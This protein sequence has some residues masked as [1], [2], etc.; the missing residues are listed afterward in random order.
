MTNVCIVY[1]NQSHGL[2]WVSSDSYHMKP[3][4]DGA[5]VMVSGVSVPCH[6]W[7]E[8]QIVE[9]KTDGTWKPDN[10]MSNVTKVIDEFENV[11]P[12]CQLLLTY[13]NAPSHVAKRKGPYRLHR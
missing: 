13:D 11:Y 6:G 12:G 10:I 5:T 4:G 9:P 1:S 8:L 7:I 2:A 3:K